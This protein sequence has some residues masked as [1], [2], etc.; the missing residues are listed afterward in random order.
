MVNS[1][2]SQQLNLEAAL[3]SFVL[4]KNTGG[5]L[6]FKKGK[7]LAVLGPHVFST[8]DL[9]SDYKGDEQ[10]AYTGADWKKKGGNVYDCIPT[11]A[12]AFTRANG[13]AHTQVVQGVD[14]DS[15][16]ADGI[17]AALA[18]AR[19]AEQVLVFIGI[20]NHQEHEGIDRHNTSLPGLQEPFTL[21]VLAL[22][23]AHAI[24]VAVVLI[25]GGAVAID[26]IVPA[27][28]AIV[29]A[30]YPSVRGAEALTMA[31]FGEANRFGKSP[32]TH[33]NKKYITEVDFHDF[34]LSK[35]PGRTY[36][37]FTGTPLFSFGSGLS[38]SHFKI[39]CGQAP[40]PAPPPQGEKLALII[41]CNV[42]ISGGAESGD[43]VLMLFHSVG[44]AIRKAAAHP[45]PIKTLV[46]FR[47]VSIGGTTATKT[48]QFSVG[49]QQLGLVDDSG[50]TQ[51]VAGTHNITVSNGNTFTQSFPVEVATS[52]VLITVPPMP[53]RW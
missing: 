19:S 2:A 38:Y 20:G 9:M 30:F 10:C 51:L 17:A 5:V 12:A 42:G 40:P 34:S 16:K 14:L 52:R 1:T 47:R 43:E 18:A 48:V 23:R 22:C 21:Q 37:Y 25:N 7:K 29:E 15:S 44:V 3:Q 35:P 33:Y 6:P 28:D 24:P 32:I 50:A 45:V 41:S 4:L 53:T 13:A 11:I 27:A 8:R 49:P 26:P 31:L 39:T 46:D 36:K